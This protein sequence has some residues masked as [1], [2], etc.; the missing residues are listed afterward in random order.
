MVHGGFREATVVVFSLAA[1]Y[2]PPLVKA[3]ADRVTRMLPV[4]VVGW[5]V[6]HTTQ[7]AREVNRVH[8]A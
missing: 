8:L 7:W 4:V 2:M 6:L 1:A 3:T 5:V